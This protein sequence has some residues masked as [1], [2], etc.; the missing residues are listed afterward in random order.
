VFANLAGG[1]L[2]QLGTSA[3]I[4]AGDNST[5]GTSIDLA[6]N[7]RIMRGTVDIGAYEFQGTNAIVFYA[8]VQH[9][10]VRI[11]G[12]EDYEDPDGDGMNNWQEWVCYTCPTNKLMNLRLVSAVPVGANVV[13]RWT[14]APGVKYL[15]ERST[16]PTSPFMLLASNLV[17][18]SGEF[19]YTDTNV[20]GA[21]PFSYRV[22][23]R[24]PPPTSGPTVWA[25]AL[26]AQAK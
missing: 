8:W 5:V 10:G 2:R 23:V 16:N 17:A 24:P 22:G 19:V 15:L 3:C 1:D 13:V 9:H 4:D 14:S 12:T 11:D 7:P 6:G 18:Q 26:T 25:P 20:P 21:G